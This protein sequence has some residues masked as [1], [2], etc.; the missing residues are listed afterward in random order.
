[1]AACTGSFAGEERFSGCRITRKLN[2]R[3]V[4][5][6]L[7]D[8]Q[9]S[10]ELAD[11]FVSEMR[12]GRHACFGNSVAH[13]ALQLRIGGGND[14]VTGGNI[15][16]MLSTAAVTAVTGGAVLTEEERARTVFSGLRG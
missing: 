12:E 4:S 10:D 3:R 16:G 15:R 1:M 8:A 2:V 6:T 5:H 7:Q 9:V 11:L 13:D 14:I